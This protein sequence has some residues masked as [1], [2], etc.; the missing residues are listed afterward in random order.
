M[1]VSDRGSSEGNE[2]PPPLD[3]TPKEVAALADALVHDQAAFAGL[4]SRQEQAHWGDKSL[5]G[6][7]RP[8]ERTSMEPMALA[9]DGGAVQARPQFIG[10]GQWQ[11]AALLGQPW[12]LGDETLGEADGVCRVDGAALPT[13]GEQSVGVARQ[14]CGRLGTVEHCPA[15]V[16]AASASRTGDTRL[17]RRRSLPDAWCDAAHRERW[18]TGGVPADT[19]C[20]TTPPL[21]LE[22]LRAVGQA[23]TGRCRWVTCAAACGRAPP[24]WTAWRP[25]RG[26]MVRQ[27]PTTRG[28]GGGDQQRPCRSGRAMADGPARAA[29]SPE[30][31]P[32]NGAS[33]S[34]RRCPQRR[35]TPPCSQRG[36]QGPWWRSAPANA[37]ERYARGCPAQRC[38]S[39]FG[40]PWGRR[41]S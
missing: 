10:P 3:L 6:L 2:A 14:W 16:F 33:S 23:G 37:V 17:D 15:G 32:R 7:R 24:A 18:H 28:A 8:I 22:R 12:S 40:G 30:R 36:V 13:P 19:L 35:G 1:H 41:R 39:S 26:G 27:C 11:D 9:V 25:C 29:W 31:Q 20:Q 38:G 5:Q 4:Y 21:A 34:R